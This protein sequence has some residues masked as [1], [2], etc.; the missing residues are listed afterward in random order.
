MHRALQIQEILSIIFGHLCPSR[1]RE[2]A[3]DLAALA[4]T[5]CAFKGPALDVLWT[6]FYC[7]LSALARCLPEACHRSYSRPSVFY[8]AIKS[9]N[10]Y[11]SLTQNEW[12]ILRSYTRRIRSL[13]IEDDILGIGW[14][15]LISLLKPPTGEPL[16]SNLRRLHFQYT[17]VTRRLLLLPLPSLESLSIQLNDQRS[18]EGSLKSFAE[19]SPSLRELNI[20]P[21]YYRKIDMDRIDPTF[22]CHWRNLHSVLCFQIP[23]DV[24]T[25]VY[26]SRMPALTSLGFRLRSNLPDEISPSDSPLIFSN[27]KRLVSSSELLDPISQLL[28]QIRLPV[29]MEVSLS[30]E[31]RPSRQ[32]LSSFLTGVQTSG[33]LHIIQALSLDQP[34]HF[35][36]TYP[37]ADKPVLG[38]EDLQ[39]FMTFSNLRCICL[40]IEW[41]VDLADSEL[42]T[43]VSTWPHLEALLINAV[44]GWNT[45]GGITPNGL[46]Q[47]LQTCPSLTAI[48]LVVDTRGYTDI[49]PL[50][51]NLGL[52]WPRLSDI[53]VLDSFIEEKSVPAIAAFFAGLA[54][55][56]KFRFRYWDSGRM[57]RMN[58][59]IYKYHWTYVFEQIKVA[60]H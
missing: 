31:S 56:S 15:S 44:W 28:S 27:L 25:L 5:C 50:P 4:R 54:P 55:S 53:D 20:R 13:I 43:L 10:F 23:L 32:D 18:V 6:E 11:R 45:Q 12:D 59:D 30:V 48:A 40:D 57:P 34:H 29:V 2:D 21:R 14:D 38:L 33:N 60:I 49:P 35:D 24:L 17:T 26:L 8:Y 47:L 42:L 19:I 16:F 46:L 9:Y 51:A 7:D 22:I 41:K 39:P 52:T 3:R 58:Q 36:R 1:V 37:P